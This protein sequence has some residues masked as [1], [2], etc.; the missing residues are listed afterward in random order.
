MIR[1]DMHKRTMSGLVTAQRISAWTMART[2][3]GEIAAW[4]VGNWLIF[5]LF[6][7]RQSLFQVGQ[8][9][10]HDQG[11]ADY[12]LFVCLQR[13]HARDNALRWNRRENVSRLPGATGH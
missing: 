8:G 6:F 11:T 2:P 5:E 1:T 13:L 3:R 12:D 10:L 9:G 7:R 4:R